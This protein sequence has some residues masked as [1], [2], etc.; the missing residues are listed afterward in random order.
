MASSDFSEPVWLVK[1]VNTKL[2]SQN[3]QSFSEAQSGLDVNGNPSMV[4]QLL[5]RSLECSICLDRLR[6]ADN[7][8]LPCQHTYHLNCLRLILDRENGLRCPECRRLSLVPLEKLL[9]N[10]SLNKILSTLPGLQSPDADENDQNFFQVIWFLPCS[11]P[12]QNV[13]CVAEIE[14]VAWRFR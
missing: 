14:R 10:Y 5:D 13:S 1:A 9:P 7:R 4:L 2:G 6:V 12:L 8:V 11:V 3:M